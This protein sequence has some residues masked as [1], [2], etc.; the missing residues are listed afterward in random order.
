MPQGVEQGWNEDYTPVPPSPR[1][2]AARKMA[3]LLKSEGFKVPEPFRSEDSRYWNLSAEG[4]SGRAMIWFFSPSGIY[5]SIGYMNVRDGQSRTDSQG[6]VILKSVDKA[7]EYIR[8]I[9]Q[10]DLAGAIEYIDA[11]NGERR[12]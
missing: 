6:Q 3:E 4:E 12:I 2:R 1:E 8:L 7:M 5:V 9:G 11:G 10:G